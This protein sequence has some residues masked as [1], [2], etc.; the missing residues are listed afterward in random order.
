MK[1]LKT[2]PTKGAYF[3][4][5]ETAPDYI[6]RYYCKKITLKYLKGKRDIKG[7]CIIINSFK[8]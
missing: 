4:C 7:F 6:S 2:P 5:V 8:N 1:K 3:Y